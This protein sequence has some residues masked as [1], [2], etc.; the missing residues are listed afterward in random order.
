ML[1][2]LP[3]PKANLPM[4]LQIAKPLLDRRNV[5]LL[6]C[7][8][9]DP[10]MNLSELARRIGMSTPAVRERLQKLE[11][12]AV[13]TAWKLELDPKALGYPITA[14][15]RIRP[16]P[17]TLPRIAALAQRMPQVTEAYRITG[18]DCFLVKIHIESLDRLD[19][20]LDAFLAFGQ[21]TTSL[22]QSVPVPPRSLPLP[23]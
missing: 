2:Q 23:Q 22:V 21:T 17:G 5:D 14:F 7:L 9:A 20:I 3:D 13:I 18:E 15:V 12:A 4:P 10:R 19:H 6:R 1:D 11:D 16:S 8:C